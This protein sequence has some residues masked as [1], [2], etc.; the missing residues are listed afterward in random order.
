MVK[1]FTQ[2]E[3][4]EIYG[5]RA[6]EVVILMEGLEEEEEERM[7][8]TMFPKLETLVLSN[9]SQLI[10]FCSNSNSQLEERSETQG[11]NASGSQ[12]VP[13]IK[14]PLEQ[15][16]A[17]KLVFPQVKCLKLC[18]LQKFES[19][20]SQMHIIEWPSLKRMHVWACDK[21]Q[22]FASTF[23]CINTARRNNQPESCTQHPLFWINQ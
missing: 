13:I 3:K 7:C 14:S 6:M 23:P 4:L 11:L 1:V 22:I 5:C 9:L 16:E 15:T 2:L 19:F 8:Q 12:V 17:T 10:R 20:F 18:H 21:V